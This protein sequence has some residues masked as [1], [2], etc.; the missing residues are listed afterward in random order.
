[1]QPSEHVKLSSGSVSG[2]D[3][4]D[5]PKKKMDMIHSRMV[6]GSHFSVFAVFAPCL[7]ASVRHGHNQF[8]DDI[9]VQS[10]HCGSNWSHLKKLFH[11]VGFKTL[12][13]DR[14]DQC[15]THCQSDVECAVM[16]KEEEL[17]NLLQLRRSNKLH[18]SQ[19]TR[20]GRCAG[21]VVLQVHA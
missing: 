9:L 3:A 21:H 8:I 6:S 11:H 14:H 19:G 18:A 17:S 7:F 16:E 13:F 5:L 12:R 1:M 15:G 4:L 10:R 2:S 20:S